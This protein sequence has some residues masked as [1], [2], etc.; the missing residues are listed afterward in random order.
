MMDGDRQTVDLDIELVD[1]WIPQKAYGHERKFQS[2]LQEYLDQQL[3]ENQNQGGMPAL[4]GEPRD[5][6]VSTERGKSVADVVVDDRVGIELKRDLSNSQTKK[7]RGQINE[8]LQEYPF[9]IA[10]ACGIEDSDGWRR[11]KNDLEGQSGFGMNQQEV[12]FIHKLKE[13]F[14]KDPSEL[15]QDD[16]GFLGGGGLF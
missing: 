10:C 16:G 8:Y 4:G 1:E 5:L 15:S 3:N 14:G 6:P 2:E 7:L 13:N 9:V 12:V 11:L